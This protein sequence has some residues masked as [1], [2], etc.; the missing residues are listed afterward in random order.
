[1]PAPKDMEHVLDVESQDKQAHSPAR[2]GWLARLKTYLV[3]RLI[4][5]KGAGQKAP[6]RT[7]VLQASF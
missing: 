7:D 6:Q 2:N 1:M 5:L 4:G 3:D